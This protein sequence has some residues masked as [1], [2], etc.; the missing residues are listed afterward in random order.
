MGM[1]AGCGLT[2]GQRNVFLG[3]EAGR[4]TSSGSTNV[5]LGK[6]AGSCNSSG[7]S[8]V[9]IGEEAGAKKTTGDRNIFLGKN[10][11]KG[12]SDFTSTDNIFIGCGSGLLVST[13]IGSHNIGIGEATFKSLQSTG[14]G[15]VAVG[16]ESGEDVTTGCYNFFGG[17][18]AGKNVNSGSCNVFLGFCAGNTNTSGCCNIAI[19]RDVELPSATGDT[20]LAIGDGTSRWIAGDSSY[21]VTVS[22]IATVTASS[23]QLEAT[24][25][26]GD[27]SQLTG[28]NAGL[29]ITNDTST[30]GTRY[31]LF[32]DATSGTITGANVSSSKLTFNPSSGNLV[33]GGTVTANSDERLKTNIVD[34]PHALDKLLQLRGVEFDRTDIQDRQIGVIAQ[35]V[36][37]VIPEVVYGSDIK[38]VAYAN[39][40][41]LLIEAVKEQ[42]VKIEHQSQQ[43]ADLG[44]KIG[45]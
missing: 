29:T 43:I 1:D 21:N 19:G 28:L 37:Q 11:G 45:G 26:K 22:G 42:N 31:L 39:M 12:N 25:F 9:I 10:A 38:S 5:F 20:Q 3:V 14:K 24:S 33:V 44:S 34:I 17:Y 40:V 27:G 30:N 18:G 6:E 32:D 8:S 23:G 2:S 41:A 15:N 16:R 7:A 4:Y 13:A 35:E 36:E